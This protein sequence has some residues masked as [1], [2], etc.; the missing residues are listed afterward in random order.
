MKCLRELPV[1][2]LTPSV[3]RLLSHGQAEVQLTAVK[4]L[5][6]LL[7]DADTAKVTSCHTY[8]VTD[9]LHLC[10]FVT[11]NCLAASLLHVTCVF[12]MPSSS[13]LQ[14]RGQFTH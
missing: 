7:L 8:A 10:C 14:G 6:N 4:A 12:G 13:M 5:T 9:E 2:Q 11:C 3:V 1:A